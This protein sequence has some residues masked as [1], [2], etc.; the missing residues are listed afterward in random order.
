VIADEG[1]GF[2]VLLQDGFA[3][4]AAAQAYCTRWRAVAPNCRVTP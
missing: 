3:D 2:F 1:A 4:V